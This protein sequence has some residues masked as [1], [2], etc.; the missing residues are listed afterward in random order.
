MARREIVNNDKDS[1]RI[2]FI[3]TIDNAQVVFY[4]LVNLHTYIT[5]DIPAY[6]IF[7]EIIN[8]RMNIVNARCLNNQ[9][10]VQTNDGYDG[11][12]DLIVVEE[13]DKDIQ[14][15]YEWS[16]R[17]QG[18]GGEMISRFDSTKNLCSPSTCKIDDTTR[19]AWT[20]ERNHTIYM[21][22]QTYVSLGCKCP[23]CETKNENKVLSFKTW[24]KLTNNTDIL[25]QFRSC[26][27]NKMGSS[28]IAYDSRKKVWWHKGNE[29]VQMELC[30]ATLKGKK[31]PFKENV[32][33]VINLSRQTET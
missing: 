31:P 18:M 1:W 14:T 21:D 30:E 17:N 28:D 24:A 22:F 15:I 6:R 9:L 33:T 8:N 13:F 23:I 26:E 25:E 11:T 4:R 20:C 29:D 32:R 5:L 7:D 2:T 12:E 3:K 19:L 16:V 10:I 27:M